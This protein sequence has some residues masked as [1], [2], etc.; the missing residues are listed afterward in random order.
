MKRTV[1]IDPGLAG[2]LGILDLGDRGEV[3]G[4]KLVRT[5]V[6]RTRRRSRDRIEYDMPAMAYLLAQTIEGF[7]EPVDI[8][9]EEQQAMP[10]ALHGRHQGGSSTF[11]VGFGFG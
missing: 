1:G 7:C 9:L 8:V 5:P 6:V 3:L 10:R 11:R 4:V 2:G